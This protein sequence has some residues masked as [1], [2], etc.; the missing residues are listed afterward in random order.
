ME[1]EKKILHGMR[2]SLSEDTDMENDFAGPWFGLPRSVL[3]GL[4]GMNDCG[5]LENL[6]Y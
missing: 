6:E 5:F 3:P 1:T 2:F 4:Y